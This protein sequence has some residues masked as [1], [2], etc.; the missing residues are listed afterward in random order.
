MTQALLSQGF[1][2]V[3]AHEQTLFSVRVRLWSY[4]NLGSNAGYLY[5]WAF[6]E[7]GQVI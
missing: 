5:P 1:T 7:P 3:I 6:C 2:L 4:I